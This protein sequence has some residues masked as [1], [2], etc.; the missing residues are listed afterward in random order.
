MIA[1]LIESI[2]QDKHKIYNDYE[3]NKWPH[4]GKV[5]DSFMHR[6]YVQFYNP[7]YYI[8]H[9]C[10]GIYYKS[11]SVIYMDV[12]DWYINGIIDTEID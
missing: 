1:H 12:D 11:K 5:I 6:N 2:R 4:V 3:V 7:N 10:V 9:K 8:G